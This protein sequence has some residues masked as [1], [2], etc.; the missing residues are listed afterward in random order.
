ME[1]IRSFTGLLFLIGAPAILL[2]SLLDYFVTPE[3]FRTFLVYRLVATLLYVTLYFIFKRVKKYPLFFLIMGT[4]IVSS[5]VE[6][7]ILSFGGH[8]STYYAGMIIVFIFL[9]GLLPFSLRIS[10]LLASI[11]YAIYLI[12]ILVLDQITNMRVFMNNNIFL[13]ATLMSVLIWRH[14][15]YKIHLKKLSLEYDLS[16]EQK[17]LKTYSTQLEELVQQRTK[18]L[19][20][21]EK[22]HRSIFDNATEGIMVLDNNGAIVNVNK[23]ACDLHGFTGNALAGVNIGLLEVKADKEKINERLSRILNGETLTYE[24]EHYRKD[25]EK[26][27]L[28]ISSNRIDSEG[29]TYIQC[30][31]RDITE[32]KKIQEQLIHS[33]KME[34]VG[35]LAGGIAH[36]FNNILT[37]ILGYSELLIEYS[38][39]DDSSKQ[40]VENIESSARKA[41]V[42][43]SKLLGFARR[44][45]HEILPLNLHH[46][47]NDSVKLFEGVLDKKIGLKINLC[48]NNPIIE[49]DPNQVEQVIMN[50][51]VNAKDAMPDGGLI[52]IKTDIIEIGKDKTDTPAYIEQGKYVVLTVSDTGCGIPKNIINKVFDPFFTTKE[53]G[54]GTGL[55]L[56]MVYG[57]VKDHRGYISVQSEIDKGTIFDIYLPVSERVVHRVTKPQIFSIEGHENILVVDDDKDVLNFIKDILETHGYTVTSANNSLTA[58]DI[59]R[60]LSGKISLVITDVLMPLMEGGELIKQLKE[61]KPDI[62]I[63]IIS[64]YSDEKITKDMVDV[65]IRKP[66]ES[67]ELLSAVRRLLDAQGRRSPLY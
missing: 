57:I 59:F 22:W 1:T 49:G 56:A 66:F 45:K 20:I 51:I 15:N 28:E 9:F 29:Q 17:Q 24:T 12:P 18:E 23:M 6:L 63:I 58:I 38:N 8:Q 55:G 32:K 14:I 26:V 25:G 67:I 13:F 7:M 40:K 42:M 21:S 2:L 54:K 44:E 11:I 5:M 61:I 27:L 65:F 47:I 53:K 35:A 4:V 33:Q 34:S 39:L 10:L 50:L 19:A 41:G 64:G 46:V 52:T 60:N 31:C 3:N 37:T 43:V 48:S 16:Q 30:F 62:K 36:N